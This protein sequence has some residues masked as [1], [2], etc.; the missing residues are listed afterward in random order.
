VDPNSAQVP[1]SV[2]Y[3]RN[4]AP[5]HKDAQAAKHFVCVGDQS[6]VRSHNGGR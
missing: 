4:Y 2:F 1:K 6:G 3:R 5:Q